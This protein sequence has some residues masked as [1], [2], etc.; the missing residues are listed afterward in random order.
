L[1]CLKFVNPDKVSQPAIAALA[2]LDSLHRAYSLSKKNKAIDIA[3]S[4][5]LSLPPEISSFFLNRRAQRSSDLDLN[6]QIVFYFASIAFPDDYLNQI[7][8][9]LT[10]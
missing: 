2:T 1:R 4:V 7:D 9:E 10:F 6:K 5:A 3:N 8:Y